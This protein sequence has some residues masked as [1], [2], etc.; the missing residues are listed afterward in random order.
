V[1]QHAGVAGVAL[2]FALEALA[3]EPQL[4]LQREL[5]ADPA[6]DE[7]GGSGTARRVRTTSAVALTSGSN[8][9][10]VATRARTAAACG[11]TPPA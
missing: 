9:K 3:L 10:R 6:T 7:Q 5:V 2:A 1:A 4:A 8:A 11:T